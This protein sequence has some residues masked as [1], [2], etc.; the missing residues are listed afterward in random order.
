MTVCIYLDDCHS[1]E[2][3]HVHDHNQSFY[4]IVYFPHV[5]TEM[6]NTIESACAFWVIHVNLHV[7]NYEL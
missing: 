6:T 7:S 2:L 4:C 3:R 1:S 5:E